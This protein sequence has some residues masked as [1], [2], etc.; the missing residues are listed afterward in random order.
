MM[1]AAD[2]IVPDGDQP[3]G[4]EMGL[5]GESVPAEDPDA[6]ECGLQEERDQAFHRQW[7][8]EHVA[9]QPRV[10]RPIHAELELLNQ[11]RHDAYSDIDQEQ[12][13]E[14]AGQS[15]I[16][17]IAVAVPRRLEQGDKEGEP[18]GHGDEEEVVDARHGELPTGEVKVHGWSLPSV[19][20]S[21]VSVTS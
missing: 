11:S 3:D 2:S 13:A 10:R 8:A 18:D 12:R 21:V 4:D 5:P 1:N 15:A 9:H 14:E 16:G 7:A 6:E 17:L 20:T 19:M